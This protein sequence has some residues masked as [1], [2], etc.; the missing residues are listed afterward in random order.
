MAR[1]GGGSHLQPEGWDLHAWAT[2]PRVSALSLG[3]GRKEALA[4]WKAFRGGCKRHQEADGI[5]E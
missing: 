2:N 5:Y 4:R 1:G 3:A